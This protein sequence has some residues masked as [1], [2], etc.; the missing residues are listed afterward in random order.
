[1]GL[2]GGG[3]GSALFKGVAIRVSSLLLVSVL[4]CG[5]VWGLLTEVRALRKEI[6]DWTMS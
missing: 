6:A 3:T 4:C 5:V 1:M 2:F